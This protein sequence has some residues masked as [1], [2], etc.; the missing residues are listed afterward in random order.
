MKKCPQCDQ[1]YHDR[2]VYCPRDGGRLEVLTGDE[3]NLAGDT[4][5]S[6]EVLGEYRNI[7]RIARTEIGS[8]YRAVH[9]LS[10]REVVLRVL[11]EN[12]LEGGET[13]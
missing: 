11:A 6:E 5:L 8:V 1:R 4:T 13:G 12:I 2:L 10:G 7:R 9:A 3:E